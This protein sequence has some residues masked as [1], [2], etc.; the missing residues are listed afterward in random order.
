M[1]FLESY[2]IMCHRWVTEVDTLE[3]KRRKDTMM[4][5]SYENWENG[6]DWSKRTSMVG[7]PAFYDFV[8][9][10]ALPALEDGL[11]QLEA[12]KASCEDRMRRWGGIAERAEKLSASFA[13]LTECEDFMTLIHD[14]DDK[15]AAIFAGERIWTLTDWLR[16]GKKLTNAMRDGSSVP[17]KYASELADVKRDMASA[18]AVRNI[19]RSFVSASDNDY[20]LRCAPERFRTRVFR[21]LSQDFGNIVESA[22]TV[23]LERV[24]DFLHG[25]GEAL[26]VIIEVA[27]RMQGICR[28]AKKDMKR[29]GS[30][31]WAKL[32]EW[33]A[34]RNAV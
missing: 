26:K 9:A 30:R 22:A 24:P 21:D 19:L 4:T 28:R 32:D 2:G 10:K 8:K 23:N 31:F 11:R 25:I 34:M 20:R 12:T 7:G 17:T 14:F 3:T 5:E 15:T 18:S 1:L 27:N 13:A 16:I 33:N 6:I 29:H